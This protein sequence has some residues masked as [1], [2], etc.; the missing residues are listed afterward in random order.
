M[1]LLHCDSCLD[2]FNLTYDTKTCRCGATKG[3]YLP[4]G[5]NAIYSGEYATPL[6]FANFS[7]YTAML[8]QPEE[9]RGE[10]FEAFVIPKNCPTFVKVGDVDAEGS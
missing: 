6:G 9:G 5:V 4:D 3:K 2:V 8:R 7:F 1:K 10:R